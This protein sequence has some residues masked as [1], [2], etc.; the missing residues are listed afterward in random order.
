MIDFGE[1]FFYALGGI[2]YEEGSGLAVPTLLS[3]LIGAVP[4]ACP[5]R[6]PPS[7]RPRPQT[8][9][10]PSRIS[11]RSGSSFTSRQAW[12]RRG[13]MRNQQYGVASAR[14]SKPVRAANR[15]PSS[16]SSA[17][18]SQSKDSGTRYGAPSAEALATQTSTSWLR[19]W[20]D[21]L[22]DN[23]LERTLGV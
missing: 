22:R 15:S 9:Q 14:E 18:P 13:E 20:R 21:V 23:Q 3:A 17:S 16:C 19:R 7:S 1:F 4:R 10:R 12:M 11:S 2:E 5:R 6:R 8:N